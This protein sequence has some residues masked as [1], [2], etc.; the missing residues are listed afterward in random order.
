MPSSPL[1]LLIHVPLLS[2]G[3]D[4]VPVFSF[5]LSLVLFCVVY[6]WLHRPCPASLCV[7]SLF[8]YSIW[9]TWPPLPL[10][11]RALWARW[12]PR[13][14]R[15][16]IGSHSTSLYM[17]GDSFPVATYAPRSCHRP[18]PVAHKWRHVHPAFLNRRQTPFICT[19][20]TTL[21]AVTMGI[22]CVESQ[23][24]LW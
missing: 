6:V 14:S 24:G 2:I 10:T 12:L 8:A 21:E 17:G 22:G 7:S 1:C 15:A 4:F 20:L 23:S 3:L 13:P 16:V 19:V 9:S 18:S 5:R 11:E